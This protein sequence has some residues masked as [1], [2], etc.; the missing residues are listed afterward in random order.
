MKKKII[1]RL[2]DRQIFPLHLVIWILK[3]LPRVSVFLMHFHSAGISPEHLGAAVGKVLSCPWPWLSS[4]EIASLCIV[5]SGRG[6]RREETLIHSIVIVLFFP[7][8]HVIK[9]DLHKCNARRS[10]VSAQGGRACG[11]RHLSP[12][13]TQA[14]KHARIPSPAYLGEWQSSTVPLNCSLY[15]LRKNVRHLLVACV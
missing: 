11:C 3:P 13:H 10:D 2:I 1:D 8:F 15:S 5:S 14:Q 7:Y 6:A 12:G 4:L 9:N